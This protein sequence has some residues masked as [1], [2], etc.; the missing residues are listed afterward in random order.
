M[1]DVLVLGGGPAGL[2]AAAALA[3]RGLDV[4]VLERRSL[5]VDKACGEGLLPGGVRALEALGVRGHI[6]PDALAPLRAIRWIQE[7]GSSAGAR[8]PGPGGLGIRRLV[9]SAALAARAR[10]AGAGLREQV[11]VAS[12]RRDPDGVTLVTAGGEELRARLLVAADGLASPVREREGLGLPAPGPRRF[13]LRRHLA[14]APWEDAVE[15]HFAEGVEAYV[16]PV[17]PRRVG[18]AFLF[19]EGTPPD[20]D[21]LLRRFPQLSGR[22][23]GAP[24]DSAPAGAGPLGRRASARIADRLLLAGDAAG[25]VDA[26]TGEGVSLALEEAVLLGRMLPDALV[27]GATREALLPWDAAARARRRRHVAVTRLVLGMARRPR[28]RRTAVRLLGRTPGLLDA[29]VAGAVG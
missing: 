8:L 15:V 21:G 18:L 4:L 3:A 23:A 29:L 17:G 9:L 24:F 13:G 22:V 28:L 26:I 11:A 5:P 2:A 10:E 7:D 27:R 1:R 25:Y 6:G 19:Q 14:V 20:F 12:H 16:T